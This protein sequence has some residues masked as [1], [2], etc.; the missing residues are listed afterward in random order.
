MP[1]KSSDREK[2]S[3]TGMRTSEKCILFGCIELKNSNMGNIFLFTLATLA[4]RRRVVVYSMQSTLL[5]WRSNKIICLIIIIIFKL[6]FYF[7][8]PGLF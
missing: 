7:R 8:Q 1:E 2:R 4:I 3:V 6:F 5:R